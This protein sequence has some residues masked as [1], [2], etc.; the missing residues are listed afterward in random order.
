MAD[1]ARSTVGTRS[2]SSPSSSSE[3]MDIVSAQ[4]IIQQMM[5]VVK[6]F[7]YGKIHPA[8]AILVTAVPVSQRIRSPREFDPR[9]S[10]SLADPIRL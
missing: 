2:T 6:S 8:E 9:G 5:F 1:R 4:G 10:D 7:I 3:G